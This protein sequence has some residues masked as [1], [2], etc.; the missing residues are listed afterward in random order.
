[1]NSSPFAFFYYSIFCLVL[2][3]VSMPAIPLLPSLLSITFFSYIFYSAFLRDD[4]ERY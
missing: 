2:R 3:L 4:D 1:M